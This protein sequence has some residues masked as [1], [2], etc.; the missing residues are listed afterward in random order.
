[1]R[2]EGAGAYAAEPWGILKSQVNELWN[3]NDVSSKIKRNDQ[4]I[5]KIYKKSGL[6]GD[7]YTS[8]PP[9]GTLGIPRDSSQRTQKPNSTQT[10]RGEENNKS[11]KKRETYS[12]KY[13]NEN[14]NKR[15]ERDPKKRGRRNPER[16]E[17]RKN[18]KRRTEQ[19]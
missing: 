10:N 9:S 1:M 7:R 8:K 15:H 4:R 19:K 11:K 14:H 13:V 3:N 5:R 17:Q 16:N 12:H 18:E 6:T 2:G